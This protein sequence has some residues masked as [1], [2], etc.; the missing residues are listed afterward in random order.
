MNGALAVIAVSMAMAP[1]NAAE[2]RVGRAAVSITPPVGTP[3]GSSYGLSIS[4]GVHD[5][6]YAK[7]LVIEQGGSR[8]ALVACDLISLQPPL[9][10]ARKSI[11]GFDD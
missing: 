9:V 7:A 6:L 10:A 3:L 1:V 11:P 2:L 4:T 5:E 8:A